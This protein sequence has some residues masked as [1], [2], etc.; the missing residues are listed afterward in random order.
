MK[1]QNVKK[2]RLLMQ[3]H[4]TNWDARMGPAIGTCNDAYF[5]REEPWL[6]IKATSIKQCKDDGVMPWIRTGCRGELRQCEELGIQMVFNIGSGGKVRS[7]SE[8]LKAY[9]NNIR[10]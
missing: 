1:G 7:S 2:V 5:L 10:K 9:S 8:L 3:A 6:E 4:P